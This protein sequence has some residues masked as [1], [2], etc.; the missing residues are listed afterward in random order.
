MWRAYVDE[1]ESNQHLDPGTYIFAATLV[2]EEHADEVREA[3]TA[4][5]PAGAG[6]LHWYNLSGRSRLAVVKEIA[7]L[8]ALHL[9][10]VRTVSRVEPSER[11]G[12]K[13]LARLVYEL[14]NRR[15]THVAAEARERKTNLRE[16]DHLNR[17]RMAR[18]IDSD[19]R[20]VHIRGP[21]E[22]ILWAADAIA[23]AIVAAR[24]GEPRYL[25]VLAGLVDIVADP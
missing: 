21:E 10:V 14:A 22:P 12:R 23:G 20:Y 3:M 25:E 17:L 6:K 1:S 8:P 9:V 24:M 7:S 18:V 2:E 15:V 19:L 16:L 4:L 5:R 11:R 13:C